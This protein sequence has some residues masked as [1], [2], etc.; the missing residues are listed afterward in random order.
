MILIFLLAVHLT[1]AL[2][3]KLNAAQGYFSVFMYIFLFS[4]PVTVTEHDLWCYYA[5]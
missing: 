3:S 1:L 2:I 5:V 4:G